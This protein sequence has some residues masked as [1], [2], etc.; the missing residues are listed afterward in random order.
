MTQQ[1]TQVQLINLDSIIINL[2]QKLN[3]RFSSEEFQMATGRLGIAN[4]I[5]YGDNFKIVREI[6][7]E[8]DSLTY[9]DRV[10]RAAFTDYGTGKKLAYPVDSTYIE[11]QL[12]FLK[13]MDH[14]NP[15]VEQVLTNLEGE[16]GLAKRNNSPH[17]ATILELE[18]F[19]GVEDFIAR[20][21]NY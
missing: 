21:V 13:A 9:V 15:I 20:H 19:T 1:E 10:V 6:T 3:L 16:K 14:N 8:M 11:G 7:E 18:D 2:S 4:A 12:K 5:L 17:V